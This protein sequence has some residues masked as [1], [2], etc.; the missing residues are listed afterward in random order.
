MVELHQSFF[1]STP[2]LVEVQTLTVEWYKHGQRLSKST[3]DLNVSLS[4]HVRFPDDLS[5]G[6][7]DSWTL[8]SPVKRGWLRRGLSSSP[9]EFPSVGDKYIEP[10]IHFKCS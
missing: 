7:C 10:R 3:G 8:L 1:A 4:D 9:P 5:T 2:A 6:D